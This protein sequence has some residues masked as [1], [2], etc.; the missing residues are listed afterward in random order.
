MRLLSTTAR[1][2]M[3]GKKLIFMN[4]LITNILCT[5][6]L[7]FQFLIV[8][9]G[10]CTSSEKAKAWSKALPSTEANNEGM[11]SRDEDQKQQLKQRRQQRHKQ[12]MPEVKNQKQESPDNQ[13]R[14]W[15]KTQV[16]AVPSEKKKIFESGTWSRKPLSEVSDK[17][18]V[19]NR[20]MSGIKAS[21]LLH[22]NSNPSETFTAYFK[23]R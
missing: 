2:V 10:L 3:S 6:F 16:N 8:L 15:S 22:Y 18:M 20:I 13:P 21:I 23:A 11:S 9:R 4:S 12:E 5:V 17:E 19:K 7:K 14:A 1:P